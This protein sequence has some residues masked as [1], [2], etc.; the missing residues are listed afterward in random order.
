MHLRSFRSWF[1][2]GRQL[3][4]FHTKLIPACR[5]HCSVTMYMHMYIICPSVSI[6]LYARVCLFACLIAISEVVMEAARKRRTRDS[7]DLRRKTSKE[8]ECAKP[9]LD[10]RPQFPDGCKSARPISIHLFQ[11]AEAPSLSDII[12]CGCVNHS[13]TRMCAHICMQISHRPSFVTFSHLLAPPCALPR[14]GLS[15]GEIIGTV[16][17]YC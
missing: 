3:L 9:T 5:S 11:N 1:R 8:H 15:S 14:Q 6:Y 16:T 7:E 12:V 13:D 2:R 4:S 17:Y 10:P